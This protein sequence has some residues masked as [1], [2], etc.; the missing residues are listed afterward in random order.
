[1]KASVN[2][3]FVETNAAGFR[4]DAGGTMTVKDSV[5]TGNAFN[6]F[7]ANAGGVIN[8]HSCVASHNLNGVAANG[9]ILRMADMTI[10]NNS[11]TGVL[12]VTAN[13]IFTFSDNK[14][15]GNGTDGTASAAIS[16]R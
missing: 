15:A 14:V 2:H 12:P 13:S 10:M 3:S 4:A 9:G 8:A 1:M 16:P 11:G 5:S 6:G 7:I